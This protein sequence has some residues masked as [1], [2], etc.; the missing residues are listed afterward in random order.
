MSLYLITR[1]TV[2]PDGRSLLRAR[3][4]QPPVDKQVTSLPRLFT[5]SIHYTF[6]ADI[7]EDF[8]F[9]TVVEIPDNLTCVTH[10]DYQV[11]IVALS[12]GEFIVQRKL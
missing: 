8:V 5:P 6:I 12:E 3:K 10:A 4:L 9:G 11:E 2:N 1:Y 7:P